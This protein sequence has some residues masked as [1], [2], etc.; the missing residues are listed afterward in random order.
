MGLCLTKN[1]VIQILQIHIDFICR[2]DAW[3]NIKRAKVYKS[4]NKILITIIALKKYCL[5]KKQIS[6]W[7]RGFQSLSQKANKAYEKVVYAPQHVF[8]PGHVNR[9]W[10]NMFLISVWGPD[11]L[12][13]TWTEADLHNGW[14]FQRSASSETALICHQHVTTGGDSRQLRFNKSQILNQA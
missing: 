1:Q 9:L 13:N 11:R 4:N 5:S 10:L 2:I 14:V 12:W 3:S 7:K 6:T 8:A